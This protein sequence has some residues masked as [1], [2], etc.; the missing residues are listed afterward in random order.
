M[1]SRVSQQPLK[2]IMT[3]KCQETGKRFNFLKFSQL[4][5]FHQIK[6]ILNQN[7]RNKCW[8]IIYI[9][10]KHKNI[11]ICYTCWLSYKIFLEIENIFKIKYNILNCH[12][13]CS[14][15]NFEENIY[16]DFPFYLYYYMYLWYLYLCSLFSFLLFLF[17]FLLLYIILSILNTY[18]LYT[19]L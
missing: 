2:C 15:M 12:H 5:Y 13:K 18:F 17:L 3:K 6:Y 8:Y 4:L 19:F 1:L 16:I 11:C 9:I 14:F 10:N 7:K